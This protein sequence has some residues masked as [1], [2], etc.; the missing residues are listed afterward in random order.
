MPGLSEFRRRCR[1]CLQGSSCPSTTPPAGPSPPWWAT[2][3]GWPTNLVDYINHFSP[4][5][6]DVFD[7]FPMM[8]QIA[9]LAKSERLYRIVKEFASPP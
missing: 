8:D 4:N 2:R 5:V 3:K 9:D 6:R 7:G 1:G